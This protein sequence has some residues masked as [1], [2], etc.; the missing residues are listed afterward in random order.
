VF[1]A[2]SS[3]PKRLG[4]LIK[5]DPGASN[6]SLPGADTQWM[7]PLQTLTSLPGFVPSYD[8]PITILQYRL[9][10]DGTEGVRELYGVFFRPAEALAFQSLGPP[11]GPILVDYLAPLRQ[12]PATLIVP[13]PGSCAIVG[14][15]LAMG[16]RRRR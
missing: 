15:L 13:T 12:T 2:S 1:V 16:L 4:S 11:G 6:I 7:Q 10:L 8:N 9:N 5:L 3:T 14:C